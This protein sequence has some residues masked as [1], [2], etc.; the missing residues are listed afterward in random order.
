MSALPR[1]WST[2]TG[3]CLRTLGLRRGCDPRRRSP[4]RHLVGSG[5]RSRRTPHFRLP[6]ILSS[7][8]KHEGNRMRAPCSPFRSLRDGPF[9]SPCPGGP[10]TPLL[11][12]GRQ[13]LSACPSLAIRK[14][15]EESEICRLVAKPHPNI[16]TA[17]GPQRELSAGGTVELRYRPSLGPRH[18]GV[19]LCQERV[20]GAREEPKPA[21]G[22]GLLAVDPRGPGSPLTAKTR[23]AGRGSRHPVWESECEVSA[24]GG[25]APLRWMASGTG[26]PAP[27]SGA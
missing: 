5:R 21:V 27:A 15:H 25:R 26:A 19:S 12:V 13:A 22:D 8:I 16:A 20:P 1:P 18:L 6:P 2:E 23:A 10:A 11:L 7:P 24:G 9:H 4:F 17:V 14:L 3:G